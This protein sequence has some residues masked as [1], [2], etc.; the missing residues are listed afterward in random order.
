MKHLISGSFPKHILLG[1][2]CHHA[3]KK[4][5]AHESTL[6]FLILSVETF[7]LSQKRS[8][9]IAI[10][11]N[12]NLNL[13]PA[14]PK[15]HY[16]PWEARCVPQL[17]LIVPVRPFVPFQ[18]AKKEIAPMWPWPQLESHRPGFIGRHSNSR[19]V[20]QIHRTQ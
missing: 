20:K 6:W 8:L 14:S 10:A 7:H 5:G 12:L 9:Y 17:R 16:Q 11:Q 19:Q 4:I 18:R 3:S 13:L 15:P 2:V 1:S